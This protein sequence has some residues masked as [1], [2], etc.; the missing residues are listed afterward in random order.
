MDM[1]SLDVYSGFSLG[2]N[3]FLHVTENQTYLMCV[4]LINQSI[5]YCIIDVNMIG[6][7][8]VIIMYTSLSRESAFE[9]T[10]WLP[11]QHL[12]DFLFVYRCRK[13]QRNDIIRNAE[14][15]N[16]TDSRSGL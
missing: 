6:H 12:Y 7:H 15:V 1:L 14:K 9:G 3:S 13:I 10:L 8:Y 16:T 11:G 5:S 4:N 2:Q